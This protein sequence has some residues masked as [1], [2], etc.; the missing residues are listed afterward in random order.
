MTFQEALESK[1]NYPDNYI[2]EHGE[3]II[4]IVAPKN[5]PYIIDWL[6]NYDYDFTDDTAKS[7]CQDNDYWVYWKVI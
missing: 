1:K 6:K 7:Y 5:S 3:R 4:F 2:N